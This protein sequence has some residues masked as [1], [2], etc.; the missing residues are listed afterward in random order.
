MNTAKPSSIGE[1]E[2]PQYRLV[3]D[4]RPLPK[5]REEVVSAFEAILALGKV[6][7]VVVELGKPIKYVRAVSGNDDLPQEI[8]D[9]E[10]FSSVRNAEIQ[11]FLNVTNVPLF[12][13]LFRAFQFLGQKR[14]KARAFL[15]SSFGLLSLKEGLQVGSQ[16][17]LP[18]IFG[19]GL[20]QHDEIPP[21]VLLLSA[22]RHG[23]EEINL[24]LRMLLPTRKTK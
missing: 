7:K 14:L 22:T 24:T 18:E 2:G 10:E 16:S 23:E 15:L 12:E 13:Y 21:D 1:E 8:M 11:E 17:A 4:E 3:A 5:T 6:Q 19:V 20:V 9:M